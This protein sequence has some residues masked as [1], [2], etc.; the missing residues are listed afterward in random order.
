M[1]LEQL[2][3]E[4]AEIKASAGARQAA[5]SGLIATTHLPVNTTSGP[6]TL[7]SPSSNA[8]YPVLEE[9]KSRVES[10]HKEKTKL[11]GQLKKQERVV[12]GVVF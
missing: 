8:S 12:S 9:L 10:L 1:Q 5:V 7:L 4:L 11:E 3:R 2:R 6:S